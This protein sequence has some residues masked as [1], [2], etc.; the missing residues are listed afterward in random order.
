[1]S[2]LLITGINVI[3]YEG[4]RSFLYKARRWIAQNAIR[5]IHFKFANAGGKEPV[6]EKK[7]KIAALTMVYNEA[8]ILPYFLRHY[9]YLDEIHVLYET[10]TTDN[11]LEI[12]RT[13]PNV[14]VE[15]CHI[16]D[17]LDDT[18]KIRIINKT[19]QNIEADWVYVVDP[20]EFVFPPNRES[21]ISFLSRQNCT[22]VRSGIY[23]VYRHHS[24]KDLDSSLPPV[25]QR[26]HGDSDL[27][28]NVKGENHAPNVL[29]IK[30]NIV[31][32]SKEITYFP[33]AHEIQGNYQI[34]TELFI[35]AHWQM[36]D[37]SIALNRRLSRKGRLSKRNKELQMGWQN[38]DI[39]T[40][41]ITKECEQHLDDPAINELCLFDE[42]MGQGSHSEIRKFSV[43]Y[44]QNHFRELN[45]NVSQA[46]NRRSSVYEF[47]ILEHPVCLSLPRRTVPFMSWRQ[48]IPFAML[49]MDLLKP[50]TL[51]ELGVHYGDSYCAFCQAVAE[52]R[53]NTICY[54]VDTWQGDPH[55]SLYG[56]EVLN[57]LAA[58]HNPLYGN[59]SN[60]LQSTF[61]EA[62]QCFAD[63]TIDILHIDGYHTYE[64]VKH[65]FETWLPKMS[66]RGTILLHDINE[67]KEDFGAW[68]VWNE[69]ELKYP[70]FEFFHCHGLG[71][72][73]VGEKPPEELDWLFGTSVE[74]APAIRD[75]F[76]CLGE[77]LTDKVSLVA[78]P[79]P[80]APQSDLPNLR[81]LIDTILPLGSRRRA[82]AE[83]TLHWTIHILRMI[84]RVIKGEKQ[85]PVAEP[86]YRSQ[87]FIHKYIRGIGVIIGQ[88]PQHLDLPVNVT[89]NHAEVPCL[90]KPSD[91]KIGTIDGK[92]IDG[93]IIGSIQ[94][95]MES[96]DFIICSNLSGLRL[97]EVLSNWLP[98]LKTEGII[99]VVSLNDSVPSEI[100][101]SLQ[102]SDIGIKLLDTSLEV[103][104]GA[105]QKV[106]IF[107]KVDYVPKIIQILDKKLKSPSIEPSLDV[108]VP[109]Y[110]AYDDLEKCLYSVFK[111]QDIY[112]ITLIN[113]CSSDKRIND[114]LSLLNKHQ[115]ERFQILENKENIGF[116][117]T[118]NKAMQM[119]SG[120]VILLNSDAIVTAGWASK[121]R[122][123]A[124]SNDRI[125]TV[126]PFTNNGTECS[127]PVMGQNNEVPEGFTIDS[128]AQCVETISLHRYPELVTAIGFCMYIRRPI[129]EKIGYF[130]E[131][132][133]KKGYGEETDFS[134]RARQIGYKNLLCDNTYVFHKGAASFGN[135]RNELVA[136][137]GQTL[138]KKH[139]E[140]WPTLNQFYKMNPLRELQENIK[141]IITH[142]NL[143]GS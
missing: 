8:L 83:R 69:I 30:P 62:L 57:D 11:S 43:E 68:K 2:N 84:K 54:G 140:F 71:V 12:L 113:D 98:I 138:Q 63:G 41:K 104:N 1:M 42:A 18:E 106:Y 88:L 87:E 141:N 14:V 22:I 114:L 13:A 107:E 26:V 112:R 73:A 3:R 94:K 93:Q 36:A 137:C 50:R 143:R 19:L 97:I 105:K 133:F 117:K 38:F 135:T 55:A 76:F 58:H 132:N 23:Q 37:P 99:Y 29:Y 46:D 48:H 131:E 39:T 90:K 59:F 102:L 118:V 100:L 79:A 75:F 77:R 120:D 136:E 111:H 5:K 134:F 82:L 130:D 7:K 9:S 20:D 124:Y 89:A 92:Q 72:V 25:P 85:Q 115:C 28:S 70:H 126:T 103:I 81:M 95:G 119:V 49:L 33:G 96:Y 51:V 121:M 123:C 27:F 116:L 10:D 56:P 44:S 125:A 24:D 129:F 61:D 66:P 109:I 6:I 122:A 34:S 31:K 60:L 110:N 17:G 40:D 16:E 91:I 64:A 4:W 47:N 65:D 45:Q 15:K 53:L 139:P 101:T 52:L 127:I 74:R 128:F 80:S 108:I 78:E 35:G 32:P 86:V 21:A 67:K 142:A